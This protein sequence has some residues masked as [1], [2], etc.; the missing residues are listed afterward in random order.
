MP[1]SVLFIN[2]TIDPLRPAPRCPAP[3]CPAP[4]CPAPLQSGLPRK[5]AQTRAPT[6]S[7]TAID[8]SAE[9]CPEGSQRDPQ[10]V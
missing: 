3:P 8:V 1:L 4:P 9:E 10:F 2:A 5:P 7:E 6:R